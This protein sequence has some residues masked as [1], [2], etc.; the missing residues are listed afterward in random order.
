MLFIAFD[1]EKLL[2]THFF[3]LCSAMADLSRWDYINPSYGLIILQEHKYMKIC[4]HL[5][6]VDVG[7]LLYL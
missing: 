5:L 4:Q 1:G 3:Y 2:E 7:Q 6:L